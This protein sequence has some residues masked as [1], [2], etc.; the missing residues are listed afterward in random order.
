MA[1]SGN[2]LLEVAA[3]PVFAVLQTSLARSGLGA[4][5]SR[6]IDADHREITDAIARGDEDAAGEAMDAHLSYLQPHYRRVW[7][8]ARERRPVPERCSA[9]PLAGVRVVA[10]EQYGAGPWATL[11][12]ADLGAEVI[13]IEDPA[14]GG[15][16]GRYVPPF[17]E[18]EDSLFFETFNRGKLS[19]SLDLRTPRRARG[20]PGRPR[21]AART[22][23]SRTSAAT[24]P[25]ASAS[26][27]RRSG[28]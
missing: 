3:L 6:R 18:G 1:A 10:V 24:S 2:A 14:V 5:F 17:Q 25:R 23:S 8:L 13:K 22:S 20:R 21:R 12:L 9:P 27:T 15:D 26:T 19:L 11:Q 28:T 4:R 16:V 7:R